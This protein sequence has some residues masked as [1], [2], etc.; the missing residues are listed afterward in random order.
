MVDNFTKDVSNID[1]I[2]V[3]SEVNLVGSNSNEW[4]INTGATLHVCS[5]KKMFSTFDPI[6]TGKRC[7]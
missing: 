5:D 1:I 6:G 2:A 7:S 3:S 4:W